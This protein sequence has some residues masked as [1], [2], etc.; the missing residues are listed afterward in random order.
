MKHYL[1]RMTAI[2]LVGA[3]ALGLMA[4]GAK[5]VEETL[6]QTVAAEIE[7]VMGIVES[8]AEE[9]SKADVGKYATPSESA[10]T[11]ED[12]DGGV[13]LT[14]YTGEDTAIIIPEQ[15]G[16]MDVVSIGSNVFTN[17]AVTG[18]KIP[19]T[20]VAIEE[21]AFF[22]CT[23]LVEIQLGNSVESIG[24]E[25]FEGCVALAT[26][27]L[28]DRLQTIGEMAFGMCAS[29]KEIVLPNGLQ[30]ICGGAFGSSGLERITIPGTVG[31]IGKQ[32]FTTC[33]S[34][35]E[36]VIEDGVKSIEGKAFEDCDALV[37]V[38]I[39]ESVENFGYAVFMYS[40]DV[41]VYTPAGSAAETYAQENDIACKN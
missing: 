31:T 27:Q 9:N 16:G 33:S 5:D 1:K 19:D 18:V 32:A 7:G 28:D 29:L 14:G 8:V 23:T 35:S 21:R 30:E 6:D 24:N 39:P 41:T 36:V 34:L 40:Y 3:M 26:V 4:C 37:R 15:L 38:E 25:A 11:W 22:Y 10:F 12:T 2:A 20:V 13:M 17:V